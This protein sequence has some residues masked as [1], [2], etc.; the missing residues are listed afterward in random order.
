[1]GFLLPF[2]ISV[3][4]TLCLGGSSSPFANSHFGVHRTVTIRSCL[5]AMCLVFA[6]A[7]V[8]AQESLPPAGVVAGPPAAGEPDPRVHSY[9]IGLQIGES[10]R[11]GG[12]KIDSESLLAGVN[13]ALSGAKPK[14]TDEELAVAM[15]RMYEAQVAFEGK[16]GQL[17]E[18]FCV[19]NAKAEGVVVLPSGLQY[20]VLASGPEGPSPGPTDLVQARYRGTFIDGRMFDESGDEPTEFS[21]D[22]VI[23]GWTE[24]LQLMKV[25][26]KWQLVVPAKLGYP[27]GR[28]KIPPGRTLV[29]E[30]ELVGIGAK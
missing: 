25:G 10:F 27:E 30:I 6:G 29:F 26:D 18:D 13:D 5:I 22:G 1:M 9:A 24:A 23:A 14:Y 20:K 28:G 2:L 17:N 3:L 21:V 8:V 11:A 16:Q 12:V 7:W 15:Q 4:V 19:E